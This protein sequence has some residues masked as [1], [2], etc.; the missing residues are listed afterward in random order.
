MAWPGRP[1][2]WVGGSRFLSS[3]PSQSLLVW[4]FI[5]GLPW[6][7]SACMV[8]GW[9]DDC[10]VVVGSSEVQEVNVWFLYENEIDKLRVCVV[11]EVELRH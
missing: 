9:V 5:L 7:A 11:E 10:P 4:W 2:K 3:P 8:A 6:V 1:P